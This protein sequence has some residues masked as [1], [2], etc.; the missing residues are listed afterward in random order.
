MTGRRNYVWENKSQK[1]KKRLVQEM[2]K[3]FALLIY[4]SDIP[5]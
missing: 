3:L 4:N 1:K 2:D 5:F